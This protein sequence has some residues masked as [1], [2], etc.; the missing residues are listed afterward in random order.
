MAAPALTSGGPLFEW[1]GEWASWTP[2]TCWGVGRMDYHF[3]LSSQSHPGH[4]VH[5]HPGPQR[6]RVTKGQSLDRCGHRPSQRT[7]GEA[8]MTHHTPGWVV[9]P[10]DHT[11]VTA[12]HRKWSKQRLCSDL[13]GPFGGT[14]SR[15]SPPRPGH[16]LPASFPLATDSRLQLP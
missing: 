4:C 13:L 8:G 10:G 11:G 6:P 12:G 9:T 14:V 15:L 2:D 1:V 16:N 5:A 7:M 3:S